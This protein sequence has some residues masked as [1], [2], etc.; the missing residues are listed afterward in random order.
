MFEMRLRFLL[1][2]GCDIYFVRRNVYSYFGICLFWGEI[3]MCN[4]KI[5]LMILIWL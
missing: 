3:L 4:F 5:Y 1:V 2:I